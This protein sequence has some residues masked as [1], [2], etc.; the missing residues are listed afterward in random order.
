MLDN[1]TTFPLFERLVPILQE[2]YGLVTAGQ[3]PWK[4]VKHKQVTKNTAMAYI[5]NGR[6]SLVIT[7]EERW[8]FTELDNVPP[9]LIESSLKGK[10]PLSEVEGLTLTGVVWAD[11]PADAARIY[12]RWC[13]RE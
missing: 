4:G 7:L 9:E 10:V 13:S 6:R 11:H 2:A 1:L 8:S 3:E 5:K 12:V